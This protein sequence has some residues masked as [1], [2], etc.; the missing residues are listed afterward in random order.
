MNGV[1][2]YQDTAISTQSKGRIIV[3]LYDG[4]VRFLKLAIKEIEAGNYT[5]KG[6]YIVRVQDIINELNIV[7]DMEI[8]GEIAE[9]LRNIYNF[10]YKHLSEAN[11]KKDIKMIQDVITVLETLNEGWKAIAR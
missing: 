2:T 4:A 11:I 8:G 1:K 5:E 6:R 10:N 9:N 7:L 3:M